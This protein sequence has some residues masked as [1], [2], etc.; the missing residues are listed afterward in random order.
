MVKG[1]PLAPGVPVIDS[2]GDQVVNLHWAPP[3]SDQGSPITGYV[4][5]VIVYQAG[6]FLG[7]G[8][9]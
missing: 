6:R 5:T 1:K 7:I 2:V 9:G 8:A 3:S 4:L